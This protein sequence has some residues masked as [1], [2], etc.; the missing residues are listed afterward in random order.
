MKTTELPRMS[1]VGKRRLRKLIAFLRVL[2]RR[3]FN[4]GEVVHHNCKTTACAIGWTPKVFP[5]I[6][7]WTKRDQVLRFRGKK[8]ATDFHIV[9]ERIFGIESG[10]AMD[11]FAPHMQDLVHR[12]LPICSMDATPKQVAAMLC[13]YIKLTETEKAA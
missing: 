7:E 4:F 3:R 13:A 11:L 6:V 9:A 1:A 5:R 12:K 10:T 8:R 2:P